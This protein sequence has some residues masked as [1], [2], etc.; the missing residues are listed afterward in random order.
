MMDK[1]KRWR[2]VIL[3]EA[4]RR[5]HSEVIE[6]TWSVR[7]GGAINPGVVSHK[8]DVARERMQVE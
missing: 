6:K 3:Q 1:A 8:S 5:I 4:S 2:E 7:G